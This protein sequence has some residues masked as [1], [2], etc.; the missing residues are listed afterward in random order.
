MN[1]KVLLVPVLA[2]M[3]TSGCASII[4]G[5][6]DSVTIAAP[7]DTAVYIDGRKAGTGDVSAILKRGSTYVISARKDGCQSGNVETSTSFDKASLLGIL[8]DF[9]IISI[10]LDFVIGGA[11]EI[12]PKIYS[13]EADCST[14]AKG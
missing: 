9:G 4:N 14:L 13:V 7:A 10:P 12:D 1:A 2:A 8:I 3:L 6:S 5:T 11:K